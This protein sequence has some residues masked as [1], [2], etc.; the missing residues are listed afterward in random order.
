MATWNVAGAERDA[1]AVARSVSDMIGDLGEVD[2]LIVQ[3]VITQ[4]QVS[5]IANAIGFDHWVI[6]D[7]SPP[8][9]IT[10]SPYASLE[11]AVISRQ[12]IERVGEWDTTGQAPNGDNFPPRTSSASTLSEELEI[13]VGL[14]SRPSRGFLRADI[15]NG[16]SVYAVHWKSSLGKSCNS[17]DVGF[18]LQREDQARG[19]LEDAEEQLASGRGLIIGGDFNIQ[20]PG[21]ALRVGT[22]AME[23]CLPI[24]SC[25]GVCGAGGKDGYDDSLA[26]L[27]SLN[28][29]RI[30]SEDL[31]GT[32]IG[33]ATS[34][35]AIDHLIV[36]C[37]GAS[38]FET[39]TSPTVTGDD[40]FGSDH[41]PVVAVS[42]SRNVDRETRIR[43]LLA[44]IEDRMELIEEL[45]YQ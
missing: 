3:E 6:S 35:G 10:T 2:I 43:E 17:E 38:S 33:F 21:K 40:Y 15:E 12:P 13:T 41:R 23:D 37:I 14:N 25:T 19:L 22:T 45:L 18:A 31:D 29:A 36:T 42:K 44:E 11:V 32:Y 20:A 5:E 16:P 24:G 28:G 39:A 34:G 1:A 7:F 26:I 27:T 9:H 4:E 30:L 8:P